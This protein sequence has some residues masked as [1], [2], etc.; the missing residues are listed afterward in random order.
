MDFA[1]STAFE[2]F[3]KDLFVI[4]NGAFAAPDSGW[5]CHTSQGIR[6]AG[7]RRTA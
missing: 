4:N 3:L 6:P 1:L 5:N 2:R 7:D